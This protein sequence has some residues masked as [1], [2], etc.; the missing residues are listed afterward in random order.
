MV[1]AV[2]YP[3]VSNALEAQFYDLVHGVAA[4]PD[5]TMLQDSR[6]VSQNRLRMGCE[7][8]RA[9]PSHVSDT[10]AAR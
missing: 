10:E 9:E 2:L 3:M 5:P 4:L 6:Q 7:R 1:N 8:F